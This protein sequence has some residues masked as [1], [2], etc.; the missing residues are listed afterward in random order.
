MRRDGDKL[1]I[2]PA[3]RKSL[4]ALLAELDSIEETFPDID[5]CSPGPVDL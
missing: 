2:E 4:L 3:P 1:I 5:D